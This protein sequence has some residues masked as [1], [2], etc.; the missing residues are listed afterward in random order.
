MEEYTGK[1]EGVEGG[2]TGVPSASQAR[3]GFEA[4]AESMVDVICEG[5]YG[6]WKERTDV[7]CGELYRG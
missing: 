3:L 6:V 7:C 4:L 1:L 5:G 2:S